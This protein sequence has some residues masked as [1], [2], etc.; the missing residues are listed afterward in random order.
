[1]A[2]LIKFPGCTEAAVLAGVEGVLPLQQVRL[3]LADLVQEEVLYARIV[4]LKAEKVD[5]FAIRRPAAPQIYVPSDDLSLLHVD[6]QRYAV[7]YFPTPDCI[8]KYGQLAQ[9]IDRV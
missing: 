7:H 3:L 9:E 1:V 4:L 2:L 6:R 5:L 8:V